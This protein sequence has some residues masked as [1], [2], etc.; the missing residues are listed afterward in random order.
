MAV[1]RKKLRVLPN[2]W[3]HIDE[4]GRPAGTVRLEQPGDGTF[5]HGWVGATV[6]TVTEV[7]PAKRVKVKGRTFEQK[8]GI[9]YITFAHADEPVTVDNTAYYRKRVSSGDLIAFDEE[10]ALACGISG[11]NFVKPETLLEQLKASAIKQFDAENGEGA[12]ETL[13]DMAKEEAESAAAVAKAVAEA[14]GEETPAAGSSA[15]EFVSAK[16]KEAGLVLTAG[17]EGSMQGVT[18]PADGVERTAVLGAIAGG[19]QLPP[20]KTDE[21][22]NAELGEHEAPALAADPNS[23]RS[24]NRKGSDQ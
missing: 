8:V 12:F 18:F 19:E 7:E 11:R 2:P 9:H 13:A 16:L 4:K 21:A 22:G 14:S 1:Q 15:A 24:K 6:A 3:L 23:T 17:S 20:I 10:S 5:I